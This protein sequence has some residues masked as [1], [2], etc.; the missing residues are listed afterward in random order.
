MSEPLQ[1]DFRL[2][3]TAQRNES[4]ELILKQ[5]R[6]IPEDWKAELLNILVSPSE[7]NLAKSSA[8]Y[9]LGQLGIKEAIPVL[10][11]NIANEWINPGDHPVYLRAGPGTALIM[12]GEAALSALEGV[13]KEAQ[14]FYAITMA[15]MIMANIMRS[16]AETMKK[17]RKAMEARPKDAQ[18]FEDALLT[19]G[20][21]V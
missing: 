14:T 12:M 18:L 8:A 7:N 11:N 6:P 20:S 5:D 3:G 15:A 16:N 2:F 4:I 21:Q 19:I 17:L 10:V 1:I 13:F 9:I